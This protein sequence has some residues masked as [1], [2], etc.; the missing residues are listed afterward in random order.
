MK[1][2]YVIEINPLPEAPPEERPNP[3]MPWI[4]CASMTGSVYH[5][6]PTYCRTGGNRP[7][8]RLSVPTMPV[9][10]KPA[11][12]PE[13]KVALGIDCHVGLLPGS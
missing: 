9:A 12:Y 2:M 8:V 3:S 7:I 6:T 11:A 5:I 1:L 10:V 4:C 13:S